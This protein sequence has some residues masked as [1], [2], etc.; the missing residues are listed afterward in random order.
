MGPGGAPIEDFLLCPPQI[1]GEQSAD[2]QSISVL[3]GEGDGSQVIRVTPRGVRL[4][5]VGGIWHIVDWVGSKFYKNVADFVEEVKRFGL[6]RRLPSNLDYGKLTAE[7]RIMLLHSRAWITNYPE[8][9]N[10]WVDLGKGYMPCPKHP[11][12]HKFGD[13]MCAGVWWQDIDFP[14]YP[15]Q[16]GPTV[17][18]KMPSFEYMAVPRHKMIKP[19]YKVAA[20]AV[21]P[22]HRLAVVRDNDGGQHEQNADKARKAGLRVDVVEA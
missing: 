11:P 7:S 6:S 17:T 4:V 12:V 13:E 20:F 5:Q 22:I 21:F 18:V 16:F 8:Y 10:Y 2:R 19:Q 1:I 14:Y 15:A 9:E 3:S